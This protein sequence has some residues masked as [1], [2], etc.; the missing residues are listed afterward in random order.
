MLL[1]R[2]SD[3]IDRRESH[4]PVILNNL[5]DPAK[6]RTGTATASVAG[7]KRF[8]SA[9][10]FVRDRSADRFRQ[11]MNEAS[12]LRISLVDRFQAGE[13]IS[14]SYVSVTPLLEVMLGSLAANDLQMAAAAASVVG[15]YPSIEQ[16]YDRRE[17]ISVGHCLAELILNPGQTNEELWSRLEKHTAGKV[18]ESE[19]SSL[20]KAIQHFS[21]SEFEA[22]LTSFLSCYKRLTTKGRWK[23]SEHELVP[24]WGLGLCNLAIHRGLRISPPAIIPAE[25]LAPAVAP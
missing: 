20:L 7:T 14:E 22:A 4:L 17:I 5:S 8:L 10:Y 15:K 11:L 1:D 16:A 18:G 24:L 25:L 13:A 23:D 12:S 19:M 21:T 6:D 3:L 9:A 2:I